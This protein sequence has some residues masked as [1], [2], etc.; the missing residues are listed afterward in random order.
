MSDIAVTQMV[1]QAR[2]RQAARQAEERAAID[3]LRQLRAR[4]ATTDE[5][6]AWA[7]L[8]VLGIQV[9]ATVTI[10]DGGGRRA[11]LT[12][13]LTSARTQPW[14]DLDT[15]GQPECIGLVVGL[16]TRLADGKPSLKAHNELLLVPFP[17]RG[18]H[19]ALAP[20]FHRRK[21]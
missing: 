11:P 20:E 5:T 6:D 16:R 21:P 19:I 4:H 1:Q 17:P 7:V 10:T 3:A 14:D 13:L 8:A 2:A 15:P 18:L 9:G 12:G